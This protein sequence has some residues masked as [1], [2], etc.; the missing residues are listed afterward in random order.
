MSSPSG[1]DRPAEW[2]HGLT[3][4]VLGRVRR[5]VNP[6]H[7]PATLTFDPE[8]EIYRRLYAATPG[9]W[10]DVLG[11]YRIFQDLRKREDETEA[12]HRTRQARWLCGRRRWEWEQWTQQS[13]YRADLS[14]TREP[15]PGEFFPLGTWFAD[16]EHIADSELEF[17]VSEYPTGRVLVLDI[18]ADKVRLMALISALIDRERETAG[19]AAPKRRGPTD[20]ASKKLAARALFYKLIDRE[21][22]AA[23]VASGPPYPDLDLRSESASTEHREFLKSIQ[24]HH[25]VPLWDLQLAGLANKK[26]ATARVFDDCGALFLR[27]GP[28]AAVSLGR[29]S[30]NCQ[31]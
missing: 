25:L 19:I 16:P 15:E 1:A 18:A 3:P 12:D 28:F 4:I 13:P 2:L 22:E 20:L 6:L 29:N 5:L 14:T 10:R 31:R 17:F 7:T 21:K 8:L 30:R 26:L 27:F 11:R 9:K 24:R 23:D